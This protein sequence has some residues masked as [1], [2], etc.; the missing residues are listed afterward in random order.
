MFHLLYTDVY[1]YSSD[2]EVSDIPIHEAIEKDVTGELPCVDAIKHGTFVLVEFGE[3]TKKRC[4]NKYRYAA[5]CLSNVE[6]DGDV[7]VMCMKGVGDSGRLF[8]VDDKDISYVQFDQ[9]LQVLPEP[10]VKR[11]RNT[12][13]YEFKGNFDVFE[14]F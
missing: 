14:S 2:S 4:S 9:I 3:T 8:K 1:T 6:E 12:I 13:F 5:I 11:V 7:K 10:D